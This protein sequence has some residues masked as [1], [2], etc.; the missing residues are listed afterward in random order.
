MKRANKATFFIVLAVIA[1]LTYTAIFGVSTMYGDKK[2]VYIKGGNDIRWGIDIR[3][4]VDATFGAP[5]DVKLS[6]DEMEKAIASAEEVIKQRL[7]GQNITDYEVYSDYT[8]NKITLKKN[9]F[10]P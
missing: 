1:V 4:G 8:K 2:V 10:N 5:S 7:I 3:G 6:G 9:F